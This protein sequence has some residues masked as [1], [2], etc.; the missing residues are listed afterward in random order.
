MIEPDKT[1]E[2][3]AILDYTET[4]IKKRLG[5]N[6]LVTG[7]LGS[8]KS[9][10]GM[11][12]LEKWYQRRFN[13]SFPVAH[14]CSTLEQAILLSKDFERKGEGILIEELSI[15]A[16][17]RESLTRVNRLWNKFMDTIRYKQIVL[18]S[19][20]PF[21][22]FIDKHLINLCQIWILCLGINFRKNICVCKP[23]ILQPSQLKMYYHKFVNVNGDAI[24]LSYFKKPSDELTKAYDEIKDRSNLD[25]YDELATR[26]M[27]ERKKQLKEI[28]RKVLAPREQEAY[29]YWLNKTPPKEAAEKMGLNNVITFYKY[30]K[31]ARNKLV[32][33][34]N[35]HFAKETYQFNQKSEKRSP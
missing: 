6:I 25:L 8:G 33:S 12:L 1:P 23:L 30:L 18:I 34:K 32:V 5:C 27:L 20:A 3:E 2:G 24:D 14:I 13:E 17:S 9:Y 22:S 15:L 28:G 26:M 19:N 21:L 35:K 16:G 11:R 7:N 10:L 4:R 29:N 31:N